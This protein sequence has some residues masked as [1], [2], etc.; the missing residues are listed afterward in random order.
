[1]KPQNLKSKAP[2]R[3]STAILMALNDLALVE[4]DKRYSV[5][6]SQWHHPTWSGDTSVCEVCFAGSVMAKTHNAPEDRFLYH[7]D[8]PEWENIF[9]ALDCIRQYNLLGALTWFYEIEHYPDHV[10]DGYYTH[11]YYTH[12]HNSRRKIPESA[13]RKAE[14]LLEHHGLNTLHG[15]GYYINKKKFKEYMLEF[16]A[17]LEANGL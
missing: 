1:M 11:G 14:R 15:P 5:N 6:M 7:N 12:A 16:A 4:R 8:F 10:E 2:K 13:R 3:F 17:M 9:S